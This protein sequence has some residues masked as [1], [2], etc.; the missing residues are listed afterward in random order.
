MPPKKGNAKVSTPTRATS[1]REVLSPAEAQRQ[2]DEVAAADLAIK[3]AKLAAQEAEILDFYETNLKEKLR[4]N[5]NPKK[6]CHAQSL[7]QWHK[8]NVSFSLCNHQ[9]LLLTLF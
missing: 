6:R 8:I 9:K 5:W 4:P 7:F 2:R 3:S 1:G